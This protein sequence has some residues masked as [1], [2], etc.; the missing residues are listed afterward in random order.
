M[1]YKKLS[2]Q[3]ISDV[4]L[5]NLELPSSVIGEIVELIWRSDDLL[6]SAQQTLSVQYGFCKCGTSIEH[7]AGMGCLYRSAREDV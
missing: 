1:P 6:E 4:L 7:H 3:T 2:K 5:A